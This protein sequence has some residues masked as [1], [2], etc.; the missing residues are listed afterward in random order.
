M[1][2]W[3]ADDAFWDAFAPYFFT[4]ERIDRAA[5][6]V[7][8]LVRLLGITPGASVLDLCCGIGRHA[9]EFARLGFAVTAVDRTAPFLARARKRA[10]R[11]KVQLE[12]VQA[13]MRD[14][15]RP[16]AFDPVLEGADHDRRC[17]G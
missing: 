15:L 2:S 16:A 14:F 12:F 17:R 3:W 1:A 10:A 13:D 7:E 6:Q 9:V 11:E 4:V 5:A 8:A